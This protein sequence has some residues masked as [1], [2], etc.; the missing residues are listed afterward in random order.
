M[1]DFY[2]G[3]WEH[4][5]EIDHLY[6]GWNPKRLHIAASEL[7]E[8]ECQN[9]LDIGCGEG[10]LGELTASSTSMY[11]VDIS[12][13]AL[14]LA[15][16]HYS[17]T[18]QADIENDE[19]LEMFDVEFDAI[20]CLEVL[21]HLFHPEEFI[22]I[23]ADKSSSETTIIISVPNFVYWRHRL[24]ILRGNIP[25]GYTLY[26]SSEHISHFKPKSLHSL[27][28]NSGISIE[29]TIYDTHYPLVPDSLIPNSVGRLAPSLTAQQMIFVGKINN[30]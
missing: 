12:E 3:Y 27:L 24:N 13:T 6:N 7:T 15:E 25:E 22:N 11:G 23:L 2:E 16:E 1:K 26:G 5:K 9:I 28:T 30:S 29:K 17:E 8:R 21:E 14:K 18:T 4:R 20:V 10:T 19:I